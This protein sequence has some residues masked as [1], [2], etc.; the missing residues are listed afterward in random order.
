[1]KLYKCDK[2]KTIVEECDYFSVSWWKPNQ[3]EGF[4]DL[5][6]D[7]FVKLKEHLGLESDRDKIIKMMK[8][9]IK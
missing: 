7:C 6:R 3:G 4:I 5:C 9:K 2:C 8:V 1:M